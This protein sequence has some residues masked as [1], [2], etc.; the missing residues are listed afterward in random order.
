MLRDL[1]HYRVAKGSKAVHPMGNPMS[2]M[3]HI[4]LN[5]PPRE[6]RLS[7]VIVTFA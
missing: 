4:G 3:T 6:L 2:H 7:Q 1:G 5:F